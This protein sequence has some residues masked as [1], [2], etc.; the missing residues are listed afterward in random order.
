MAFPYAY[1]AAILFLTSS[2]TSFP[3][4]CCCQPDGI[5]ASYPSAPWRHI[6]ASRDVWTAV[7]CVRAVAD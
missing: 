3:S 7:R 2:T 1:I 6:T 5:E 4:I